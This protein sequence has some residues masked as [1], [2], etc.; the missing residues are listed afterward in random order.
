MEFFE[1]ALDNGQG[2]EFIHIFGHHEIKVYLELV[3]VCDCV[4]STKR[5]D[6]WMLRHLYCGQKRSISL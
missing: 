4:Q 2:F 1:K 3:S 5:T 6:F